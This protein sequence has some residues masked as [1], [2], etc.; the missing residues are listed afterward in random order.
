MGPRTGPGP[1]MTDIA[2]VAEKAIAAISTP[3]VRYST[4]E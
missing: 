4:V 2:L 3:A 1:S